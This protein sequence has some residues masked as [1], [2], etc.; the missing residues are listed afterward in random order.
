MTVSEVL[1]ISDVPLPGTCYDGLVQQ[2][3][4][5]IVLSLEHATELTSIPFP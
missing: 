2:V 3:R 5:L 1:I 4:R